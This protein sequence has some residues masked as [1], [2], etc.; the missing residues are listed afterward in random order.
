MS[1]GCASVSQLRFFAVFGGLL[2]RSRAA[3]AVVILVATSPLANAFSERD[4]GKI[5]GLQKCERCNLS[6]AHLEELKLRDMELA[7]ANLSGAFLAKA[8][9]EFSDMKGANLRGADLKETR[10]RDVYFVRAN[11][12]NANLTEAHLAGANFLLADLTGAN[13]TDAEWP[14]KADFTLAKFCRTIWVD[15][16]IKNKDC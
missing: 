4:L 3:L 15:G 12:T 8:D 10:L 9:L 2:K 14:D 13:F 1:L 5:V 11:L 7:G 16:S 6:K